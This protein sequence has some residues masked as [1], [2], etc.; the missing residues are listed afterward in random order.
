M[1]WDA[2]PLAFAVNWCIA[3][4]RSTRPH[5]CDAREAEAPP[6]TEL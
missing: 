4:V 5:Y 2:S 1:E 6:R 3:T